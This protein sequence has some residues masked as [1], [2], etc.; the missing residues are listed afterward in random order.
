MRIMHL[1]APVVAIA[2]LAA[3]SDDNGNGPKPDASADGA[4]GGYNTVAKIN[5]FLEGKT[6]VMEGSD[7][8]S[9]PLGYDENTNFGAATQWKVDE[10]TDTFDE[11]V[12]DRGARLAR[13]A[14]L[15]CDLLPRAPVVYAYAN[16]HYAGHGP[17]TIRELADLLPSR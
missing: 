11:I 5:A 1:L 12:L 3:C 15:L 13:W 6:M 10:K 14:A 16:N 8:P 7:I 4:G 17:A 2:L 9:H